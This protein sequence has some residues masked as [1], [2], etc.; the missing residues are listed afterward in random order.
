M[1][2]RTASTLAELGEFALIEAVTADLE[3][4]PAVLVGPGDDAA[5]LDVAGPV[6]G[7]ST[8]W[9]ENVH[10]RRS[11]SDAG[12]VGRK[13]IAVNVADIEA[14]GGRAV[15]VTVGF[16]APA[17]LPTVWLR[18]FSGG[19]AGRMCRRRGPVGRW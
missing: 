3:A 14:M 17:D 11:W 12:H 16:S 7:P 15:A 8:S 2:D 4:D 5:L 1:S 19:T 6:L 13:A 18:E 9:S 10:F